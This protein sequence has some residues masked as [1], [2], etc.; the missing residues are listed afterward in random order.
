MI[1]KTRRDSGAS[2]TTARLTAAS[3]VRFSMM[4]HP[5]L[6]LGK[7]F[8]SYYR[9][10]VGLHLPLN[11][12]A[13]EPRCLLATAYIASDLVS[14]EPGV[15]AIH[16]PSLV[17]ATGIAL[18][19][20][21]GPFWVTSQG[22][23]LSTLYGGGVAGAPLVKVPLEVATP[24]GSPTGIVFNPTTDF[25]VS[26]GPV[27]APAI[28]IFASESGA[29]SGWHPAVPPP[30]PATVAQ[31]AFQASDGSIY[32]GL[33]LAHNGSGNFLYLADFHNGQ[34]DVL[35][36]SFQSTT[37]AGSFADPNLPAGFAPFNVAAIG[38]QLF[39]TYARQDAEA[40]DAD[41]GPGRG[42]ISVFDLNG[43]FQRRLVS[44]GKLNAPWALTRAPAG[45]GDFS[46]DL[47]VGNSGD[48]RINA[49][50]VTT[51]AFQG[52]LR[53][54]PGRPLEI[55]GL[56]GLA[57]GNGVSAGDTTTLFY[58]AG[59][60][61]QTHGLFGKI[62]ANP[63]G[64]NPVQATLSAGTL[65]ISGSRNDDHVRVTL[66]R[67][68]QEIVVH[69][70]GQEIGGFERASVGTIQF[71]GLAGNDHIHV[72]E[73]IAATTLL[74]GG[75]G[76]DLLFGGGGNNVLLGGTGHDVLLGSVGRDLLIGGAGRDLLIG[77]AGD[78]LLIGGFTAHDSSA[79]ALLQILAEWTSSDS[80]NIRIDKLK[81]GAGG[82]P[83][84]DASTVMDDAVRDILVGGQG[85]DWFLASD[86]DLL[87][88][89]QSAEQVN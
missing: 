79:A 59:P 55:D 52:T 33:A 69:A 3:D 56:R 42:F 28:F 43:N 64:T 29:V 61:D 63:V 87:P 7:L 32:T 39:V 51:G 25:L 70:G 1:R 41:D 30:P 75:A 80:Y 65:V 74:D 9:R 81:N 12:E 66:T 49:Y 73:Q 19:P 71:T 46:G 18:S 16:D 11:F 22:A 85:L 62:T 54:S 47:L 40:D 8:R 72:A 77:Q 14:S 88:G 4:V 17:G 6:V 68:S 76:N 5:L 48:G 26:S 31:P 78:D 67:K 15:A 38:D 89:R 2:G 10:A 27:T 50:D 36:A 44:R 82:L 20:T 58:A 45:F 37:L 57:F 35:D 24:G 83:K 60:K 34:I 53:Q 13:L 86:A 21:Q 23:D 84:L